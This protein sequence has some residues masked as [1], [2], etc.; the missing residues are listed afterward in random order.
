M[1]A[2]LDELLK[3]YKKGELGSLESLLVENKIKLDTYDKLIRKKVRKYLASKGLLDF[4]ILNA[5]QKLEE[6]FEACEYSRLLRLDSLLFSKR[7]RK[8]VL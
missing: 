6:F 7:K 8:E 2:T 4:D 5:R 3:K 1:V